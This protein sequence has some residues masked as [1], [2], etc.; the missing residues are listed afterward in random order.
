MALSSINFQKA[1]AHS[2][3]H[4]LRKDEPSYLLPKDKRLENEFWQHPKMEKEIFD[5]E[6]ENA[7][8]KGG[9][10]PKLENSRWEAVLNLNA[11]H[12]L[13]D[14][15]RVAKHIEE[16]FNITCSAIA[17]HRDEGHIN[18]RGV[19]ERNLHAHINFVTYKDGKQ[20]WRKEH[21]KPDKLSE[22]QTEVAELLDMERGK[23]G[24]KAQ[25]LDHRQY[26][27]Q[28]QE[29]AKQKDL[30]AEIAELRSQLKERGA[31]RQQ[32]AELEALNR[33]LKA[34]IK[35]KN[36][37]V[38][39]LKKEIDSLSFVLEA[40]NKA[41]I[42]PK[43]DLGGSEVKKT[44]K[45]DLKPVS[46]L[47][48]SKENE[49]GM[50]EEG[51]I[52]NEAED[53]ERFGS[54]FKLHRLIEDKGVKGERKVKGGLLSLTST[55]EPTVTFDKKDLDQ[56]KSDLAQYDKD[57][58]KQVHKALD[59]YKRAISKVGKIREYVKNQLGL[60]KPK[61]Q[62]LDRQKEVK[63]NQGMSR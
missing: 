40:S 25:R 59:L 27:A 50:Y 22:L 51:S 44:E 52:R 13:E 49:I 34:E 16:K 30:K 43:N 56:L 33:E 29:L 41:K 39:K 38:D 31:D 61:E 15:Q 24:S 48:N 3:D 60:N 63:K 23:I 62:K 12:T 58:T 42:S 21:I 5:Q 53:S 35:A 2:E 9:P 18:E 32:Y 54:H 47:L 28:A 20:N 11:G 6:I 1:A 26:K 46:D 36:L 10:K 57:R 17:V 19:A 8:R 4:N 14:V 7:N 45:N 37:T 55:Y